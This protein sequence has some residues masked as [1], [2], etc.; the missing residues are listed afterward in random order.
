MVKVYSNS[1]LR[2]F[3]SQEE[4]NVYTNFLT[5]IQT[6]VIDIVYFSP[7]GFAIMAAKFIW[8]TV[9]KAKFFAEY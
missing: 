1:T 6:Q 5:I 8:E 3:L 4:F 7:D 2:T 9:S